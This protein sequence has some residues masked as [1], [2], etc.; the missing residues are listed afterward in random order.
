MNDRYI[1]KGDVRVL[2]NE[3]PLPTQSGHS[4]IRFSTQIENKALDNKCY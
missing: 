4:E 2:P 3:G 1:L